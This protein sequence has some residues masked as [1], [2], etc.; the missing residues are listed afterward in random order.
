MCPTSTRPTCSRPCNSG[1][2]KLQQ[3]PRLLVQSALSSGNQ[4]E[5]PAPTSLSFAS[6]ATRCPSCGAERFDK[7]LNA[8]LLCTCSQAAERQLRGAASGRLS[9]AAE[10]DW[11]ADWDTATNTQV[12]SINI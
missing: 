5:H 10:R 8:A 12:Y 7:S 9:C 4:R 1:G 2:S 11:T 6:R 3:P